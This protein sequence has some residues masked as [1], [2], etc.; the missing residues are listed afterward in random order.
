MNTEIAVIPGGLTSQLQ[1]LDVSINKPFKDLMREE[2]NIWMTKPNHD[3][4]KTGRMKRPTIKEVCTWVKNSWEKIKQE[5]IV[6]SFKKCGISNAIDGTE[7]DL[8]FEERE[9]D[10]SSSENILVSDSNES[11]EDELNT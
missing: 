11:S 4:T 9:D 5:T 8:V 3:L 10:D 2:W 7:D 6:K 1:P